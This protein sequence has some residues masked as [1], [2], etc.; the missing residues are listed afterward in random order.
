MLSAGD[1]EVDMMHLC[2][3]KSPQGKAQPELKTKFVG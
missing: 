3:G 1:P 2:L